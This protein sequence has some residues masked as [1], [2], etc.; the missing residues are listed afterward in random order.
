MK[1]RAYNVKRNFKDYIILAWRRYVTND[2][3]VL[4]CPER[5]QT[6]CIVVAEV[7]DIEAVKQERLQ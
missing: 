4:N 5:E 1:D 6:F 7:N 2:V 3:H